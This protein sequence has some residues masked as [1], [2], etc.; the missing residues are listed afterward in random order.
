[1]VTKPSAG[2]SGHWGGARHCGGAG[3]EDG[4]RGGA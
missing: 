1:M 4:G 2:L 3:P